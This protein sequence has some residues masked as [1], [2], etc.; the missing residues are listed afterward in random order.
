MRTRFLV[1]IASVSLLVVALFP[2]DPPYDYELGKRIL[3]IAG[4]NDGIVDT[5]L[6]AEQICLVPAFALFLA[7]KNY[8]VEKFPGH[9][10]PDWLDQL[11]DRQGWLLVRITEGKPEISI[12]D[13]SFLDWKEPEEETG[14]TWV[15]PRYLV[16]AGKQIV[17]YRNEE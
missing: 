8:F 14:E 17:S 2:R 6:L 7:H 10:I 4:K 15:C 5:R 3:E 11:N 13:H 1:G 9:P 16:V 12:M